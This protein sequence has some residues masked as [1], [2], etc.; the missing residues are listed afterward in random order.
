LR[1][2]NNEADINKDRAKNINEID[3]SE[4]ST[5][6][7]ALGVYWF[8]EDDKLGFHI[9]VKNQPPTKRGILSLVSSVYDPLGIASP[10][11]L[12]GKSILQSL[13]KRE[14]AMFSF[15]IC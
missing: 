2:Q 3:L 15:A 14:L 10:F 5:I 9:N 13:C 11:V 6:E 4:E 12:I 7:R 1:L 8:I